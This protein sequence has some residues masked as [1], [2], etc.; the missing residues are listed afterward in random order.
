MS[1]CLIGVGVGPGDRELLTLK[2]VR[3]IKEADVLAYTVN[4][5]GFS[6]AR[7][8]AAPF[9][10]ETAV[11][12]PL[13]FS[14]SPDKQQ[15]R[16]T[17][18]LAAQ[19]VLEYL[20]NGQDV[21]YIT[22]GD[23]LLYSTFQH[24][25]ALMPPSIQVKVC[26]GV[27]AMFAAAAAG[28]FSIALEEQTVLIAPARQVVGCL[29]DYLNRADCLVLYKTASVA[30]QIQEELSRL[31]RPSLRSILVENASMDSQFIHGPNDDW[32]KERLRY[33][34]L[35]LIASSAA[36]KGEET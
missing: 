7:E 24:L 23:P 12:L 13:Y 31:N 32:S 36:A 33:F 35:I 9:V 2:A 30:G 6:Y 20:Q 29:D 10:Q 22:E 3:L 28:G 1:G 16:Q 27:S 21:V 19:K 4:E 15:R 25:L 34:S 5:Q 26:P 17:R 11:E 8:I 18:S 14:M